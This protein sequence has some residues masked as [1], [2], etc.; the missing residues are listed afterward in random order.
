MKLCSRGNTI[1]KYL[2]NSD[3]KKYCKL[4]KPNIVYKYIKYNYPYY[5]TPIL[6]KTKLRRYFKK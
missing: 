4:D 6:F 3:D 1:N 2:I 5:F